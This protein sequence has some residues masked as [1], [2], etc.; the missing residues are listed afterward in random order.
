[1]N[2]LRGTIKNKNRSENAPPLRV[3][4]L[5]LIWKESTPSWIDF[6]LMNSQCVLTRTTITIQNRTLG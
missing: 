2:P 4:L 3:S 6:E 1:M 5:L